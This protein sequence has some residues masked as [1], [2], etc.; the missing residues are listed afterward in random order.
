MIVG[1]FYINPNDNN[2]HYVMMEGSKKLSDNFLLPFLNIIN[3]KDS[4][5]N[6]FFDVAIYHLSSIDQIKNN[7]VF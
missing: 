5:K 7:L 6:I 2:Q 3:T 1:I 4:L